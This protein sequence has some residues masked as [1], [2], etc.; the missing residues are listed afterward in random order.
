MSI[1]GIKSA[2]ISGKH[3]SIINLLLIEKHEQLF[4]PSV[5]GRKLCA[6][7]GALGAICVADIISARKTDREHIR[8]FAL[9]QSVC[10][11]HALRDIE[12]S[13]VDCARAAKILRGVIGLIDAGKRFGPAAYRQ[14]AHR[15]RLNLRYTL[16]RQWRCGGRFCNPGGN[17]RVDGFERGDRLLNAVPVATNISGEAARTPI[18]PI[19]LIGTL[20]RHQ[21]R[22]AILS[23]YRKYARI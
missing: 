12:R 17:P 4:K 14:L 21:S 9:T 3:H 16:R 20:P 10:S 22:P 6:H 8:P 5:N 1:S 11:H 7:F 13:H 15:Q 23:R 18:I 2:V 19:C